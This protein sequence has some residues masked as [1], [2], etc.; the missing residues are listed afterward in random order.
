MTS[1]A[2]IINPVKVKP[3]SDLSY[4]Q[5]ITFETMRMAKAYAKDIVPVELFSAQY[6]EDAGFVPEWFTQTPNLERS[7]MDFA[8][9]KVPRKLPLIYDILER[10]YNATNAEFLIYT[11]ADI[12]VV[13]HFYQAVYYY[14]QQG[15][16]AFII[17]RRRISGKYRHVSEIPAIISD[18][19]L[20][21]P[22][23]DCFVFHRNL[24][25][26]LTL[27]HICIGIP[28]I[29]ISLSHNLFCYANNFVLLHDKHLT[30]HIGK[31][32][33]KDWGDRQYVE[34]NR[35][36]FVKIRKTLMPK[37]DIRKFPYSNL[38]FLRRYLSWLFNPAMQIGICLPL[39]WRAFKKRFRYRFNEFF[40]GF[41]NDWR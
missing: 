28:F 25:P 38:P 7:V 41:I 31:E 4:A 6:A 33:I 15:Y 35:Q 20:P 18:V 2:H 9:F 14:I 37:F 22:G 13:P 12:G 19:G 26:L 27:G 23:F 16:D 8:L 10:L 29:E 17:N 32:V 39:D 30:F 36:E 1:I 3:N 40:F 24:F 34:F 11:N 5:P 21:H